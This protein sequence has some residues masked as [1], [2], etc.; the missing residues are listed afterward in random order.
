MFV[1]Q[2]HYEVCTNNLCYTK[3]LTDL[4]QIFASILNDGEEG[5]IRF[6]YEEFIQVLTIQGVVEAR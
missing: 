4:F 5:R 6:T 3:Q 1:K 2:E